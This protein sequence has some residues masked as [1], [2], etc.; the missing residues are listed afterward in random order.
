MEDN[1]CQLSSHLLVSAS[2]VTMNWFLTKIFYS[3]HDS[4]FGLIFDT[5]SF[6]SLASFPISLRQSFCPLPHFPY[7]TATVWLP[8]EMTRGI[9]HA[10]LS[11]S[12]IRV[13]VFYWKSTYTVVLLQTY[14][15]QR[16]PAFSW[17]SYPVSKYMLIFAVF[18][19]VFFSLLFFFFSHSTM[20]SVSPTIFYFL[21]IKCAVLY[22]EEKILAMTK[23]SWH[24]RN[25]FISYKLKYVPELSFIFSF[26]FF[27]SFITILFHW[28]DLFIKAS[29]SLLKQYY[30]TDILLLL[31][32]FNFSFCF[33]VYC[34]SLSLTSSY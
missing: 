30:E 25:A 32:Q 1:G 4:T 24:E 5:W 21:F 3:P 17:Q 9:T 28:L 33:K 29:K 7:L 31:S 27:L 6:P 14:L 20:L 22:A 23:E 15:P 19:F 8:E 10:M 13:Q 18:A 16:L 11:Q 34:F 2:L 12:I 26:S